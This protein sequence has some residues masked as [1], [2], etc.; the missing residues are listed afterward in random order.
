MTYEED[1]RTL[2]LKT[3]W[4]YIKKH[5]LRPGAAY[6]NVVSS[7]QPS[8]K[9]KAQNPLTDTWGEDCVRQEKVLFVDG[10]PYFLHDIS[11][12]IRGKR[13]V[14]FTQKQ[15]LELKTLWVHTVL[16]DLPV[17]GKQYP[18]TYKSI[19]SGPNPSEEELVQNPFGLEVWTLSIKLEEV[20]FIEGQHYFLHDNV[21]YP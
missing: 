5:S 3:V 11:Y 2:E 6:K 7:S 12:A 8:W 17:I 10:E 13:K 18:N 15:T 4:V 9:E 19:V 16:D 1:K 21:V 20:L 14:Y